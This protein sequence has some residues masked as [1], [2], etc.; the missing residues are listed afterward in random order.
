M[1]KT[2]SRI[3]RSDYI[4]IFDSLGGHPQG[5]GP[6]SAAGRWGASFST[7]GKDLRLWGVKVLVRGTDDQGA[8]TVSLHADAG[9]LPGEMIAAT[10]P[11]PDAIL[12]TIHQPMAFD[13]PANLQ[14]RARYW[15]VIAPAEGQTSSLDWA[16]TQAGVAPSVAGE[17]YAEESSGSWQAFPNS[18]GGPCQ[19]AVLAKPPEPPAWAVLFG[20]RPP[21]PR[22]TSRAA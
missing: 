10:D 7:G 9:A 16:F 18:D 2:A 13:L 12:P 1:R 20:G 3:Q 17:F 22:R 15:V 6:V 21:K 14:P 11:I 8:F 4:M 19:M 5:N